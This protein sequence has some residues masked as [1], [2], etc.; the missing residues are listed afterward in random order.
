MNDILNY[1]LT[2]HNTFGIHAQCRRFIE[3]ATADEA[4]QVAAALSDG[5]MP[6]LIIGAGSNLLLSGNF[7]GTV[8]HATVLGREVKEYDE[9]VLLRCGRGRPSTK[10][11]IMR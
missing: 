10:S 6:L 8:I 9:Y 3:Y 4:R 2:S 7:Q 5:D 1:D 11:W